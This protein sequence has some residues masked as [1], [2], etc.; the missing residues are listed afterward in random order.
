MEQKTW[1]GFVHPTACHP[2][3]DGLSIAFKDASRALLPAALPDFV[4]S[5]DLIQRHIG[6][7]LP[8]WVRV[9]GDTIELAR[10]AR[11][12]TVLQLT[13]EPLGGA[14]LL[15][16][17]CPSSQ[18]LADNHPERERLLEVFSTALGEGRPVLYALE[19]E[20]L[21]ADAELIPAATEQG[22]MSPAALQQMPS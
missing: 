13:P 21:I 6:H 8:V 3:D 10:F 19:Q 15:F 2:S 9:R 16:S 12:A 5:R 18:Y 1:Q 4:W 17:D 7:G 14:F 22:A 20:G 11:V